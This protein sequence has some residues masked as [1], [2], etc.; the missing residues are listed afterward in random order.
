[1]KDWILSVVVISVVVV[2]IIGIA[3]WQSYYAPCQSGTHAKIVIIGI[4][5]ITGNVTET[6]R[7]CVDD[8]LIPMGANVSDYNINYNCVNQTWMSK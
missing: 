1:M 7:I 4:D 6:K 2:V 8:C 3:F 5:R